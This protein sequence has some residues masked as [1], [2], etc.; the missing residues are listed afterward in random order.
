[1]TGGYLD[2][3]SYHYSELYR[4]TILDNSK[5]LTNATHGYSIYVT[6]VLR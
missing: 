5:L 2:V 6:S 4:I 3:V 1:M